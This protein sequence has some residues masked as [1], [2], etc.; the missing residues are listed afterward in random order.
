MEVF[1]M[2]G[3]SVHALLG[4]SV[5]RGILFGRLRGVILIFGSAFWQ[6]FAVGKIVSLGPYR[7]CRL[8]FLFAPDVADPAAPC[9]SIC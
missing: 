2:S 3:N 4:V 6:Y 9:L 7:F 8:T 5:A 1:G